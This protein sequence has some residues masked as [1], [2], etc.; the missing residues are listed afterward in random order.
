MSLHRNIPGER[1]GARAQ[2]V[3]GVGMPTVMLVASS[4]ISSSFLSSVFRVR[5][6]K[7]LSDLLNVSGKVSLVKTVP[8]P[9]STRGMRR[10]IKD[11]KLNHNNQSCINPLNVPAG[12][13][14]PQPEQTRPTLSSSPRLPFSNSPLLPPSLHALFGQTG[15]VSFRVE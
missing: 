7:M 9:S 11:K 6:G 2:A 5:I 15:E 14:L 12:S 8:P 1:Q 4:A 10:Q 13:G 3:G